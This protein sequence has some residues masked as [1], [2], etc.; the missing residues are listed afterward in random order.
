MNNSLEHVEACKFKISGGIL[1]SENK[2]LSN[3]PESK[4][5]PTSEELTLALSNNHNIQ[6]ELLVQVGDK[7]SKGDLLVGTKENQFGNNIHSPCDGEVL[8]IKRLSLGHQSGFPIP[9][10]KLRTHASWNRETEQNKNQIDWNNYSPEKIIQ[11]IHTAGI[12]GLGGAAFPTH[13]KINTSLSKV[14]TLI[15]NAMECEPYITCDDRLMREKSNEILQGSLIAAKGVSAKKILI[16]IENNKPE[17]I[18]ALS[19]SIQK[20]L[21]DKQYKNL[22]EIKI[23]VTETRYPS[24]GEK[25]LIQLLTGME[26]PQK[27]YPAELGILVQNV[28][29][30][31]AIYNAIV[32]SIN[33]TERLVTITGDCVPTPG[34][35]W[36]PF[37][38]SVEHIARS[39]DIKLDENTSITFGGPLMG[40]SISNLNTPTQKSTNCIIFDSNLNS[41]NNYSVEHSACIRCGDCEKVCPVSL[42]PQ[43]LYWF[44]QSEQWDTL[45]EQNL[46]DCIECGACSY[47][48]PSEIPLVGYFRF[49]KSEI[50]HLNA[51]QLKSD[52]AKLRF[53]NRE[54]RLARIKAEREEKRRKTAEARKLAAKNKAEDPDGKQRAI[55]AALE[56]V[57][58]KKE[59][60]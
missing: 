9:A 41:V 14:D 30:L 44:S 7:V 42:L 3:Q 45:Q 15:V 27:Q 23:I 53:E 50:K 19:H 5:L 12:V 36:I 10:L 56:R 49:G 17:A 43:Q 6:G 55:Q 58:Q 46:F 47:V 48:C 39:L 31:Y 51:K 38:S 4:Q 13:I 28:A 26:V 29:T 54:N 40:V 33:L 16:G 2:T 25:Q 52:K 20:I 32:N 34:N 11:Q 24:G 21:D 35:Y 59:Q 18:K 60:P 1:P 57:K 22:P 8:E 37:G